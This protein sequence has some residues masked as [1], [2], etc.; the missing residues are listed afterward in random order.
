VTD[1]AP[2]VA[3]VTPASAPISEVSNTPANAPAPAPTADA[4]MAASDSQITAQV[5]SE[6][7]NAAPSSNV[8][9]RT[10]N[11]DV[12]L[13]GSVPSQNVA[14]QAK[15]AALRVAGVKHV[16]ASGLSVSNQ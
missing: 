9:V 15:Q 3:A 4:T 5:K 12:A 7:A 11:G 16:D 14:D 10:D 1:K 13:A 6:V 8:D 2:A